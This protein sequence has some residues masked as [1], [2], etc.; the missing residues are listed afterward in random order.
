MIRP[1]GGTRV[2]VVGDYMQDILVRPEG[3][4]IPGADRRAD[5]LVT[6]GGSGANQAAWLAAEGVS[7]TLVA[8]VGAADLKAAEADLIAAGVT[9]AL[10]GDDGIGTGVIV[11]MIAPD[12]QR[13]FYTSRGANDHLSH[14]DLPATL[15]EDAALLHVSGYALLAEPS[16]STVT[17]LMAEA[18]A[19]DIPVGIDP[20]SASFLEEIGAE[21]FLALTAGAAICVPNEDEARVLAGTEVPRGQAATLSGLF[22]LLVMK[23]GAG[24]A[25]VH[26]DGEK[27]VTLAPEP[28]AVV[29]TTGA[30]DA[31][32]AG[33]IAGWLQGQDP[34]EC[35]ARGHGVAARAVARMGAR[36][37]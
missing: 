22:P 36:P 5:I 13:S 23:G 19:R 7:V 33:F 37:A 18:M 14:A 4:P 31:F 25:S 17:A 6:P 24:A 26:V 27:R 8:R 32:L 10:A 1:A 34:A 28:T 29:D 2:V 35:L 30:G 3:P 21:V 16:R 20:G 11:S 9:P 12:G 15:L